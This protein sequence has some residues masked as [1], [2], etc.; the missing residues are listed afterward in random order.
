[1]VQTAGPTRPRAA[2]LSGHRS[3]TRRRS[4]APC[5][6]FRRRAAARVAS[7]RPGRAHPLRRRTLRRTRPAAATRCGPGTSSACWRGP[8]RVTG[9]WP[10][11]GRTGRRARRGPAGWPACAR[12]AIVPLGPAAMRARPGATRPLRL[13]LQAALFDAP[14][15]ARALRGAARGRSRRRPRA[16]RRAWLR[17]CPRWRA[18][19]CVVDLV[20]AL[21]LNI[22]RRAE[23]DRGPGRASG[24]L[25]ARRLRALRA[26]RSRAA[27]QSV[28]VSDADRDALGGGPPDLAIVPE[29]GRRRA[30]RVR[31][32]APARTPTS[33]SPATS[34]TSRTRTPSPG[35]PREAFPRVRRALPA[36]PASRS[37][38]RGRPRA[39]ARAGARLPGVT[40]LGPV[41]DVAR[42]LR[43]ARVAVAPLQAGSGQQSQGRWRPWRAGRPS[44]RAPLRRGPGAAGDGEHLLVGASAEAIA[45]ERRSACS[46]TTHSRSGSPRPAARLVECTYTWE[47]SV[48][49]LEAAYDRAVLA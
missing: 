12:V 18:G 13:P 2:R 22:A 10:S 21:S 41:P 37:W 26:A 20:D 5:Q 40:V 24:G 15:T 30:L 34:A 19:P 11:T 25:E 32:R 36:G 46:A 17:S 7:T 42:V 44:S 48:A 38:A 43:A 29:R 27:G 23:R 9:S 33:S 1:M 39:R 14:R 35:S 3:D 8:T 6:T 4:G 49:L 47:R 16:A 31:R 28:V 45:A